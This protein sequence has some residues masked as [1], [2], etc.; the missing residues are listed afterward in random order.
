MILGA[1]GWVLVRE[2]K[3][4]LIGEQA[5]SELSSSILALA[6]T[7][8]GV[9]GANGVIATHL[10]PAQVVVA[11][12]L[13]FSDELRTP[14]IEEAVQS[15]EARVRDRHHEVVA[16][17]V[18]PQSHAGF[19]EAARAARRYVAFTNPE[20]RNKTEAPGSRL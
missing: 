20:E 2:S 16:L 11:L 18:K 3:G 6:E 9:D 17:F 5:G 4:L 8:S 13:E 15:L 10:A 14:Q 19:R 7:Q 1:V 12:S